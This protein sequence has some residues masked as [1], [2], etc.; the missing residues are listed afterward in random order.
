[1]VKTDKSKKGISKIDNK[2]SGLFLTCFYYN[3]I[4]NFKL[5]SLYLNL[6]LQRNPLK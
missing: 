5:F 4:K 6:F 2:Q 3:I 1:M